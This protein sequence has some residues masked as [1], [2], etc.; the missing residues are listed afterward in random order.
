[1]PYCTI[2]DVEDAVGGR[3][4]LIELADNEGLHSTDGG[5]SWMALVGRAIQGADGVI[6]SYLRQRFAVPIPTVTAEIRRMSA[7]MTARDLRAARYKGQ[8]FAEDQTADETDRKW[9]LLVAEGKIQLGIEPSPE[10][11][12]IIIDKAGQRDSTMAISSRKLDGF[13]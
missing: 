13:I 1:M 7:K 12:S 6:N 10:K 8:P 5:A 3:A 9:L 4:S 2:A 11:S